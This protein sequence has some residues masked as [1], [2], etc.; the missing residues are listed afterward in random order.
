M[1]LVVSGRN[2]DVHEPIREFVEQKVGKLEKHLSN[3]SDVRAELTV[4][5]AKAMQDHFTCQIT[6]WSNGRILRAED[7]HGDIHTAIT[8]AVDK[9]SRQIEKVKGRRKHHGRKSLAVNT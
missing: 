1:N 5:K 9:L 6:T 3:L 2:F 7:S 4:N 8:G